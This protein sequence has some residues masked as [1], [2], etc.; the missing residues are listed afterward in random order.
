MLVRN[1]QKPSAYEI[2]SED[3]QEESTHL[4]CIFSSVD[5]TLSYPNSLHRYTIVL[6]TYT[7]VGS[8]WYSC[9]GLRSPSRIYYPLVIEGHSKVTELHHTY[10]CT[11]VIQLHIKRI[12]SSIEL[13]LWFVYLT[14][15]YHYWKIMKRQIRHHDKKRMSPSVFC[16]SLNHS[17]VQHYQTTQLLAELLSIILNQ[18]QLNHVYKFDSMDN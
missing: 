6:S 17:N 13:M 8:Y 15:I 4:Q 18:H 12:Q 2:K 10:T 1:Q 5:T 3:L 9:R 7:P 16:L 14:L 11:H